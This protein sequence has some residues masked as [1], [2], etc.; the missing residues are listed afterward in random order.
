MHLIYNNNVHVWSC[1]R[2]ACRWSRVG[3]LLVGGVVE[4]S[5]AACYFQSSSSSNSGKDS[6]TPL[7]SG[8]V[9]PEEPAE[10]GCCCYGGT[11][12]WF[13]RRASQRQS[14]AAGCCWTDRG[15][16]LAWVP[17]A[18]P[19][20]RVM[21][22]KTS[23]CLLQSWQLI[24]VPLKMTGCWLWMV[25]AEVEAGGGLHRGL[26]TR[27][28]ELVVCM[29][30]GEVPG[31]L[32]EDVDISILELW[33]DWGPGESG[34]LGEGSFRGSRTSSAPNSSARATF[35]SSMV[36]F[37]SLSLTSL[38]L[39]RAPA[40]RVR[41]RASSGPSYPARIAVFNTGRGAQPGHLR[42]LL[43]LK[44]SGPALSGSWRWAAAFACCCFFF[45]SSASIPFLPQPLCGCLQIV[46]PPCLPYVVGAHSQPA[47][48]G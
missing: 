11:A 17:V 18:G 20:L 8:R 44:L 24:Q 3:G 36:W 23:V 14:G 30:M 25:E 26:G 5:L 15:G 16:Y 7:L 46:E 38:V 32:M 47:G 22:P 6:L 40:D 45:I 2:L 41:R 21:M 9:V 43:P 39:G 37:R 48:P 12:S 33:G 19:P 10:H 35:R 42:L 13:R 4:S 31:K 27:T 34:G 29:V 1:W 28:Q